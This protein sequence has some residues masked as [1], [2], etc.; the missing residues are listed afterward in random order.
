MEQWFEI[1]TK[2]KMKHCS[3]ETKCKSKWNSVISHS[4]NMHSLQFLYG[5]VFNNSSVRQ[6]KQL[7][8]ILDILHF[9]KKKKIRAVNNCYLFCYIVIWSQK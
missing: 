9:K 7:Y 5:G 6:Q 3:T 1:E 2:I 8:F 4:P